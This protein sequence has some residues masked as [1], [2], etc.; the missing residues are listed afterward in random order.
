LY[1]FGYR[2]IYYKYKYNGFNPIE[3]HID[4]K[5]IDLREE[6]RAIIDSII[7]N[8]GC[9]SG[10]IL[11]KMTH[12]EMP[13][14]VIRKGLAVN[15]VSDRIIS[16]ELIGEYFEEVKMKYCMLNISDIRDYSVDTF[17]KNISLIYVYFLG[18]TI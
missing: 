4:Y 3:E 16:K 15:E 10:K 11:E 14:R 2:N 8:L 6:E 7:T 1:Y 5:D 9:Y 18:N 13:W 17:N 12:M